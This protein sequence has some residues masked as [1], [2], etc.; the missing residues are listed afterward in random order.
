LEIP[1][2]REEIRKSAATDPRGSRW[3]LCSTTPGLTTPRDSLAKQE[4][5]HGSRELT[6]ADLTVLKGQ[7]EPLIHDLRIAEALGMPSDRLR[8]IRN[9]IDR[10]LEEIEEDGPSL[11]RE[12]M[13][14]ARGH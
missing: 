11:P 8:N 7:E 1:V 9:L 4:S 5:N 12:A 2:L 10:N 14:D 13:V 6:I 3:G